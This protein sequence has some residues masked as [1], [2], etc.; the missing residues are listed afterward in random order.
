MRFLAPFDPIVHDRRRF[1]LLWG[2][3]YRFEAYTPVAKR[4]RGYY[5]LP[6]LHRDR[7]IGWVNVTARGGAIDAKLGYAS[8]RAP[9]G[10]AYRD[11]LD[12]EIARLRAFLG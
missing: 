11:A 5:A 9:P 12:A 7:V 2:W 10:A 4:K 1:E 3:T 6:V 8:G